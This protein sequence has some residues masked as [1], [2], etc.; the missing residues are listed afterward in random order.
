MDVADVVVIGA[1]VMG[2]AASLEL[3]KA[4]MSVA[5][6]DRAGGAGHGTTSASSAIVRFNYSTFDGIATAWEA[7]HCWENWEDQ[8]G[9]DD[10]AGY[11]AFVRTGMVMLDAPLVAR[12]RSLDLFDAVGVRY[13]EWD[14]ETL[15]ARVPG[16]DVGKYWPPKTVDDAAFFAD[17]SETIGGLFTPDAGYVDDPQL[18]TQNLANAA[19]GL[20]V[21]FRF[22]ST[23][24]AIERVGG[25]VS[26]VRLADGTT[27]AASV[28][29]N[30]AGPWSG[31][32][33]NLAGVGAEFSVGVRP[34]RQEVH[35]LPAPEG[36]LDIIIGDIDLG[37]YLRPTPGPFIL[38][39]GT[40][41]EC[42]P[43]EWLDDPDTSNPRVTRARFEAQATRAARRL[44]DLRIPNTPSGIAGV[45]DVADD[46]TPIYDR[47]DLDGYYVAMGTSGNQFKNAPLAGRFIATLVAGVENGHD[48]DA[49]PLTYKG[50]F[51][52]HT[53]NLGTFSR[54]RPVNAES[55]NTVMG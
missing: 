28:V 11:A 37:T 16:I 40:E 53:I 25:R 54:K 23:V 31:S 34:M 49:D 20:G 21:D 42:D 17:S 19:A 9:V 5:V 48:H 3:R 44:P 14:S 27:I 47:T 6:V 15:R 8:V 41:P 24:T 12:E 55:S 33:N 1:G 52:G 46:W 4:G 18:A 29:V 43:F 51:T 22:R 38:V 39:G 36:L 45:Y 10:P 7:R 30:A 26:R 32:V 50:D 35:Q 13:E 2:C